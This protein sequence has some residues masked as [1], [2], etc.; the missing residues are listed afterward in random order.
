[1]AVEIP[2]RPSVKTIMDCTIVPIPQYQEWLNVDHY[3]FTNSKLILNIG[4]KIFHT[5]A[6]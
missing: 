5:I 2:H 6:L 1:M 4:M 3:T